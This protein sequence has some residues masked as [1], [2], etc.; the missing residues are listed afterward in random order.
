MTNREFLTAIAAEEMLSAEIRE[1]AAA[2]IEK[3]DERAKARAS[4]PTKASIENEPIKQK[5]LELLSNRDEALTAAAIAAELEITTQ[6]A[7]A[8]CRQLVAD[9]RIQVQDV[10]AQKGRVCKAYKV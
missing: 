9:G 6:K 10:K 3:L 7:S 5:I 1:H 2:A 8:L 4:K